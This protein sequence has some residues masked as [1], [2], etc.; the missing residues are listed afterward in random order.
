SSAI[1]GLLAEL[2]HPR[3][4]TYSLGFVGDQ[5]QS[6]NETHLARQVA[7]RWGTEHHENFLEPRDLLQDLIPMVWHL[8]EPYG[9]SL[10]S[11]YVFRQM[12]KDVKVAMTGTG[13]DEL[14]GNY[15]KFRGY[16]EDPIVGAAV[17][18]RARH[19]AS[20]DALARLS[21]PVIALT[22]YVPSSCPLIGKGR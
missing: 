4:K 18:F 8:D 22:E 5:E 2:G 1:V 20:A 14:F 10:P 12:S 11:W 15:G 17:S 9:D 21:A 16:E 13:G 19:R 3:V 6:W 7:R